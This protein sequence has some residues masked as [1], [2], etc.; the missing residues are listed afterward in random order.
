[1]MIRGS[2]SIKCRLRVFKPGEF[3]KKSAQKFR[4]TAKMNIFAFLI[5]KS[6]HFASNISD[7]GI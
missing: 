4:T 3:L 5:K 7:P 6:S 2:K 1:M